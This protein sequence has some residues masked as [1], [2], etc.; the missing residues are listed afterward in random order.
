[1]ILP[2]GNV[3]EFLPQTKDFSRFLT[4]KDVQASL[5]ALSINSSVILR[6][7]C[8]LNTEFIRAI[9]AAL[10]RAS[11]FVGQCWKIRMDIWKSKLQDPTVGMTIIK[12]ECIASDCF[13]SVWTRVL[14]KRFSDQIYAADEWIIAK[15]QY[16]PNFASTCQNYWL[17]LSQ[18]FGIWLKW[19]W[20]L[21][22]RHPVINYMHRK[23]TLLQEEMNKCFLLLCLTVLQ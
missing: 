6:D 20:T 19:S 10:L 5:T 7:G 23:S 16:L 15:V 2:L 13:L 14:W 4:L 12:Q 1:M 18:Y 22:R 21:A 17:Y 11:A 9:L 8:S 3:W